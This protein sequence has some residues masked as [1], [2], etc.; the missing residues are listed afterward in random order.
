M[1]TEW[2]KIRISEREKEIIKERAKELQM[3]MS[4]YLLSLVRNDTK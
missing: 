2:I 3:S 1:K 4:E